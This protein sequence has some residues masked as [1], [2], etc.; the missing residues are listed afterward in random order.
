MT[1]K[2]QRSPKPMVGGD[3]PPV[4]K[5]LTLL[6]NVT[7]CVDEIV[8]G[9]ALMGFDRIGYSLQ[10]TIKHHMHCI[11]ALSGDWMAFYKYKLAAYVAYQLDQEMP[12]VPEPLKQLNDSAH[13]LIGGRGMQWLK[14]MARKDVDRFDEIIATI[15]N[16]KRPM[17]RPDQE[18]LQ[19]KA[20]EAFTALTREE[21]VPEVS[22]EDS[23]WSGEGIDPEFTREGLEHELVRTV[24]EIF[25]GKEFTYK[26]MVETFFPSTK[27]NYLSSRSKGG[28][29][30]HIMTS[31][32]L[33]GLHSDQKLVVARELTGWSEERGFEAWGKEVDDILLTEK[34]RVLI[35]RMIDEAVL[36]EKK[37]TLV[38]LAE[39][40]KV[41]VISK[42]PVHTYTVLKPLQKWMWKTLRNHESGTFRLIGEEISP[43]YL[44]EQL[45]ELVAETDEYKDHFVSGDYKAATDNLAPWASECI[46]KAIGKYIQDR[47]IRKLFTEAL[48]GHDIQDPKNPKVFKKQTWGQLMGS[49]VSFPVLCIVNAAICRKAREKDLQ[50]F[51]PTRI[52]YLNNAKIAI[53]GDDCVFRCSIWGK[54]F[55]EKFALAYGMAPSQ[56]KCFF[57]R[58]FLNMNSAQFTVTLPFCLLSESSKRKPKVMFL[59]AV[60]SINLG[61][62]AGQQRSTSG[63]VG[64]AQ[65]SDWGTTISISANANTLMNES[66]MQ[67]RA[68]IFK[69]YLNRNWIKL[70]KCRLPWYLPEH[71]GGLGLPSLQDENPAWGPTDKDL[72]LAAAIHDYGSLPAKKPEGIAWKTWDY[73]TERARELRV[74]QYLI[75]VDNRDTKQLTFNVATEQTLMGKLCIESIFRSEFNILYNERSDKNTLL[76][77]VEK[78]V[79]RCKKLMG[80][81]EPYTRE[82]LP[83]VPEEETESVAL[84]LSTLSYVGATHFGLDDSS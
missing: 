61:L 49:I 7:K 55:W 52:L 63:K 45:G 72:R 53:N 25:K 70:T 83:T 44:S 54:K 50:R 41:R 29:V 75:K 6:E 60:K 31:K 38:A 28:A 15:M 62:L 48:T 9:L 10:P 21:K 67:D 32:L 71:L 78:E 12:P 81:V 3:K 65:A 18:M 51:Q 47:R 43:E 26:D 80:K 2:S 46:T 37:V 23:L 8:S 11:T 42:G 35:E 16:M 14:L 27:A 84:K 66:P 20:E 57:S 24:D 68:R 73:A 56:G 76:R 82:T 4:S 74:P 13:V 1:I 40:L 36:E 69:S 39:A 17:P 64:Q 58:R 33:Q 59:K 79:D 19:K 22:M 30:G 77:R 5:K 34:F